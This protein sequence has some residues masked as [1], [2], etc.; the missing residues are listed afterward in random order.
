MQCRFGLVG[1]Q[2]VNSFK[3]ILNNVTNI[4]WWIDFESIIKVGLARDHV[5]AKKAPMIVVYH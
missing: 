5:K 4:P 3:H 2:R 1:H